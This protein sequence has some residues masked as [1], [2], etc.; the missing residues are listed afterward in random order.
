MGQSGVG[1]GYTPARQRSFNRVTGSDGGLRRLPADSSSSTGGLVLAGLLLHILHILACGTARRRR[2]CVYSFCQGCTKVVSATKSVFATRSKRLCAGP[3][4]RW[5]AASSHCC[6]G[7]G[8]RP[9]A[10][11]TNESGGRDLGTSS[12][13]SG[14]RALYL[15]SPPC[16]LPKPS[17]EADRAPLG[18]VLSS[19]ALERRRR[20]A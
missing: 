20:P 6:Q 18:T 10:K 14:S 17:P 9:G 15:S 2:G 13:L 7:R 8:P 11:A 16:P 1:G 19:G 4:A 3:Q 12:C 5:G